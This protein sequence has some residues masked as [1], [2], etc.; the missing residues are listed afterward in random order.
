MINVVF[1]IRLTKLDIR[2]YFFSALQNIVIFIIRRTGG[3]SLSIIRCRLQL[4]VRK[5]A[6]ACNIFKRI[7]SV[8][9]LQISS[10]SIQFPVFRAWTH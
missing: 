8:D 1:N 5:E 3:N 10:L 4:F 6:I 9:V 2:E 7:S